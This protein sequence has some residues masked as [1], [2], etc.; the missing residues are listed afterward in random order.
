MKYAVIVKKSEELFDYAI[1][2]LKM[3]DGIMNVHVE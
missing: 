2:K 3:T 1:N